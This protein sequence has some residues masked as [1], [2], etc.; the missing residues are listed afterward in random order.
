MAHFSQLEMGIH[1]TDHLQCDRNLVTGRVGGHRL[2]HD[3]YFIE[4]GGGVA[5][6]DAVAVDSPRRAISRV[7]ASAS[8]CAPRAAL[9]RRV[10]TDDGAM[11]VYGHDHHCGIHFAGGG[12]PAT[13]DRFWLDDDH[14]HRFGFLFGVYG[15][16]RPDGDHSRQAADHNEPGRA[17]FHHSIQPD[18]ATAWPLGCRRRGGVGVAV[19]GRCPRVGSRKPVY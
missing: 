3:G 7:A 13:R 19:S 14:R 5:D 16:A 4:F 1:P 11:P 10:K 17:A 2:A 6:R 15:G 12:R 8:R 18:G 9:R